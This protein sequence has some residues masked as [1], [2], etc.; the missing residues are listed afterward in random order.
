[1]C[2]HE[3]VK[4]SRCKLISTASNN[5]RRWRRVCSIVT[6][7]ASFIGQRIQEKIRAYLLTEVGGDDGPVG[8]LVWRCTL[9]RWQWWA[10]L[11]ASHPSACG[12]KCLL[13]ILTMAPTLESSRL[14]SLLTTFMLNSWNKR[15]CY[16]L[17]E[18]PQIKAAE[19][20]L[21]RHSE[22]INEGNCM[23]SRSPW[24]SAR[25]ARLIS[26]FVWVTKLCLGRKCRHNY[27]S[28]MLMRKDLEG[29]SDF[30]P[31]VY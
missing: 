27:A 3:I 5:N 20:L 13:I 18:V 11:Q 31:S 15:D 2:M 30:Y 4:E 19:L 24:S 6:V 9:F 26:S 25:G 14:C 21:V 23:R 7:V 17:A 8:I 10:L 12:E 28:I 1:M 22:N 29:Q 16:F